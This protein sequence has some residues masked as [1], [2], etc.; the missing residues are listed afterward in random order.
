MY[1]NANAPSEGKDD[2]IK[3]SFYEG[4]ERLLDQCIT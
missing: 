1:L 2:D 3:D 4:I